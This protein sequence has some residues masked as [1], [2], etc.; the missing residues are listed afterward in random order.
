[1]GDTVYSSRFYADVI[2]AGVHKLVSVE[3]KDPAATGTYGDSATVP[4]DEIPTISADDV[5]VVYA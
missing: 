3:L 4:A 1:M 2:K 5:T